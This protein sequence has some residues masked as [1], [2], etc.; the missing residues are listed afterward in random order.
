MVVCAC[1]CV[2]VSVC[3]FICRIEGEGLAGK[4]LDIDKYVAQ[5]PDTLVEY[6]RLK[7]DLFPKR[8]SAAIQHQLKTKKENE[9]DDGV[10]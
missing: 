8:F 7:D 3:E 6:K 10:E 1:T 2:S 4:W 9:M 5:I